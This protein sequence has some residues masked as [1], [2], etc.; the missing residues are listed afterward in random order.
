M[1]RKSCHFLLVC[2]LKRR[3]W[4]NCH[5]EEADEMDKCEHKKMKSEFRLLKFDSVALHTRHRTLTEANTKNYCD[6]SIKN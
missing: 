3:N 6:E 2:R 1:R 5:I 4:E